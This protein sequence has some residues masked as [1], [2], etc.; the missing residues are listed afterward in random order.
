[1]APLSEQILEQLK[2]S[3]GQLA[4]DDSSSPE[5]IREA[6]ATSKKAFKQALGALYRD[7]RIEFT[8]PGIRLV[9]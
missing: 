4:L 7:R 2:A 1:V 3:G 5:A 6:F 8:K 9:R